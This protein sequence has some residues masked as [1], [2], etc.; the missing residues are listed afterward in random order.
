L[1]Q[2]LETD[3]LLNRYLD[4]NAGFNLA[5]SYFMAERL[6]SHQSVLIGDPKASILIDNTA[7]VSKPT[8][9]NLTLYPNPSL[10]VFKFKGLENLSGELRIEVANTY[11]QI[12]LEE[13]ISAFDQ[14]FTV[15]TPGI[16]FISILENDKLAQTFKLLRY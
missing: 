10:G 13:V 11:G 8:I 9:S 12:V 2:L 4:P 1:V 16:Y 6:L 3:I 7:G 14:Q 15:T 5:E